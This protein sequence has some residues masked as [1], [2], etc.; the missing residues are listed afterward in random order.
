M[1]PDAWAGPCCQ[2]TQCGE[3]TAKESMTRGWGDL[4]PSRVCTRNWGKQGKEEMDSV[5][6]GKGGYLEAGDLS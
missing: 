1:T 2:D 6:K 4:S 5:L 3:K